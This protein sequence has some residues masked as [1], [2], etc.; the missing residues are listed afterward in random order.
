M[1]GIWSPLLQNSL[2]LPSGASG[3]TLTASEGDVRDAGSIPGSGGPLEEGMAT[4]SC[5]L[6]WRI[7]QTEEPGGLWATGLPTSEVT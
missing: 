6:A 2:G 4:L 1:T 3:K 7:P 5:I